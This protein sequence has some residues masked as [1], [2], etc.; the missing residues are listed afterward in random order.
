MGVFVSAAEA[1]LWQWTVS[2]RVVCKRRNRVLFVLQAPKPR[3]AKDKPYAE[4][5][6][7]T[8]A[9]PADSESS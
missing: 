5:V 8:R 4:A 9:H 7:A 1:S 2:M 3:M 6:H